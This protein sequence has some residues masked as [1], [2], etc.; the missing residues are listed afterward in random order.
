M[1]LFFLIGSTVGTMFCHLMQ[2]RAIWMS[3]LPLLLLFVLMVREDKSLGKE[4]LEQ[5]P[6]GH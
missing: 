3:A 1:F 6:L 5:K 2:G 4:H